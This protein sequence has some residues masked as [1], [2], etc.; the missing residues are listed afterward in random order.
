MMYNTSL[1]ATRKGPAPK[2]ARNNRCLAVGNEGL[3]SRRIAEAHDQARLR[4]IAM[5]GD[6]L[7]GVAA[8]DFSHA[9]ELPGEAAGPSGGRAQLDDEIAD[10]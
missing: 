1:L 10:L 3:V 6:D 2:A 9:L 4:R 7:V 5:G 8:G